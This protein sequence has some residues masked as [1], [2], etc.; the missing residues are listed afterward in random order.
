MKQCFSL[1]NVSHSGLL[2]D[3]LQDI[4]NITSLI[5]EKR[6]NAEMVKIP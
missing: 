1:F 4:Q 5:C 6:K 2:I 3:V